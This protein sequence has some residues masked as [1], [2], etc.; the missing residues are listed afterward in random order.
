MDADKDLNPEKWGG[1]GEG[2]TNPESVESTVP[3]KHLFVPKERLRNMLLFIF[4]KTLLKSV[5]LWSSCCGCTVTNLTS[6][7]EGAG[8]IPGLT[9]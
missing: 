7:H 5:G 9:Q 1:D 4:L 3:L 8:S 2:Q 6:I